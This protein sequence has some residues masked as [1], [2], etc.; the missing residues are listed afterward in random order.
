VRSLPA[1]LRVYYFASFA[2]L[3]T[4]LP[5]FPAWLEARGVT[6]VRMGAVFTVRSIMGVVAPLVFGLLADVFGWRGSLVRIGTLCSMLAMGVVALASGVGIELGFW[7]LFTVLLVYAFFRVPMM[8]LADVSAL[9]ESS[10]YGRKRLWGSIGFLTLALLVGWLVDPSELAPLPIAVTLVLLP[11]LL[12]SFAL[13]RGGGRPSRPVYRDARRLA[14]SREYRWF[15]VTVVAWTAS[16]AGYN[17]IIS[18]HLRDLGASTAMIGVAWAIATL[19]E[20]GLMAVSSSLVG[21]FGAPALLVAGMAVMAVRWL[22]I[23]SVGSLP[24]LLALQPLHA[25]SFALI[26]VSSLAFVKE[27]APAHVLATGQ[28]LFSTAVAVG[29]G[30][31]TM[32]WGPLYAQS[33]GVPVFH[34]T[35]VLAAVACVSALVLDRLCRRSSARCGAST[36]D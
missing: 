13:P 3:G 19:A 6:G 24:A 14:G 30:L 25:I 17:L 27:S 21:R 10:S 18:L 28:G 4:F 36:S 9:E 5:F 31:G 22:L 8:L 2:A 16:H 12:A 15:L 33:G 11:A 23:G 7:A 34:A 20:V 26:W 32:V 1:A 29:G 35:A